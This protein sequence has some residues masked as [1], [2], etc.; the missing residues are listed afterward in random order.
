MGLCTCG[1]HKSQFSFNIRGIPSWVQYF[2]YPLFP[3]IPLTL[4][5]CVP[6]DLTLT[7]VKETHPQE[8]EHVSEREEVPYPPLVGDVLEIA[9][10]GQNAG[11][12]PAMERYLMAERIHREEQVL[13][14]LGRRSVMSRI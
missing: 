5:H 7:P 9:L 4:R 14:D 11:E 13:A 3:L 12:N 10:V 1:L 6:K 8:D 2:P